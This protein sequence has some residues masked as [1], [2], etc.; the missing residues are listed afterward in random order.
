MIT[1]TVM[2][3]NIRNRLVRQD[4]SDTQ[5][6]H[7]RVQQLFP[8]AATTARTLYRVDGTGDQPALLIQS[9]AVPQLTV[10]PAE[11]TVAAPRIREDLEPAFEGLANGMRLRFA[12]RANV[13]KRLATQQTGPGKRIPLTDPTQQ[14]EWLLRKAQTHGFVVEHDPYAVDGYA[15]TLTSEPQQLGS[16]THNA[17]KHA[18]THAIVRYQGTCTITDAAAF[19]AALYNGIGPAKAYGCGLLTIAPA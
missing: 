2:H 6:L 4:L 8:I 11:Y 5:R 19:K 18:L 16:R 13:T 7:A 15:L 17:E 12:L 9:I 3:L 14:V 1:L 10:L